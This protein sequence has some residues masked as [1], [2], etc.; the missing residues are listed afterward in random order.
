MKNTSVLL[1]IFAPLSPALTIGP[2]T[3][4]TLRKNS[5]VFAH[6]ATAEKNAREVKCFL[7]TSN[8]H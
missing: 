3:R 1:R 2:A 8:V 6:Q 4:D 5:F 7:T